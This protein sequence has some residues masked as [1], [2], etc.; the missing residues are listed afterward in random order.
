MCDD[1][2]IDVFDLCIMK[3]DL[4]KTLENEWIQ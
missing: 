2:I 3:R 1:D 4:L